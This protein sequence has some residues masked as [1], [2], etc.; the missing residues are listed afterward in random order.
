LAVGKTGQVGTAGLSARA[1]GAYHEGMSCYVC[2]IVSRF[3]AGTR[4]TM[5]FNTFFGYLVTQVAQ[6]L[7]DY[8]YTVDRG[9]M[10]FSVTTDNVPDVVQRLYEDDRFSS[11]EKSNINVLV[12]REGEKPDMETMQFMKPL[13]QWFQLVSASDLVSVIDEHRVLV[14][15]QP[16]VSLKEREVYGYECLSRG[17]AQD[18]SIIPPGDLF[19]QAKDLKLLFNLDRVA[20]ENALQHACDKKVPGYVFINFLP[21][22]IYDPEYCLRT[23]MEKARQ[24]NIPRDRIVFEIVESE[25]FEDIDHLKRI[26][27]YY[28]SQGVRTALDDIGSGYSSLNTLATL[29]PDIMKLD[30]HLIHGIDADSLKQSIFA[31]LQRIAKDNGII[32][33]AEGVETADELEFLRSSGVDLVQGYYFSRPLNEPSYQLPPD[34]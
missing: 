8:G 4:A 15:F 6:I 20:R 33:L 14:Q 34:F 1:G 3:S 13:Q 28:Q 9:E 16:I 32:L 29:R 2:D 31:G 24:V 30:L 11:D 26:L 27:S 5:Y 23:T 21:N 17:I 10:M 12:L 18:G 19:R 25:S 22:A 7:Q